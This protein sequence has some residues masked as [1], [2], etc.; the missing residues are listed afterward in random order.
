MMRT[1]T[2]ALLALGLPL[3]FAAACGPGHA[4]SDPATRDD[5]ARPRAHAATESG[6][7]A[8]EAGEASATSIFHA[9]SV[10]LDQEG[11]QRDL[12]SL[13]GRVQ[14]VSMVYTSCGWACP[15]ILLDLK[16]IED[17]V[18]PDGADGV[19]YVLV[20]LDPERDSPER[21]AEFARGARLDPDRWTLLHGSDDAVL[22]LAALL[23]VQYR[24]MPDGEVVHSSLITVLDGEGRIIHRQLGLEA[25]PAPTVAAIAAAR[26]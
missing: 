1:K 17:L 24:R 14:V 22:E 16:R 18:G 26:G 15:R 4:A 25:D 6:Q 5:D 21:L 13:G 2:G 20:T 19:G 9:G 7:I 8:M 11:R 23:G 12:A 3:L 10:W